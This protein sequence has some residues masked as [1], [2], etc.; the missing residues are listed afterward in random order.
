[1]ARGRPSGDKTRCSGQWTEAKFRSFIKGNLR[2]ATRKWAPI[3]QC[4]KN[5]HR[6]RG[7]YECACCHQHVPPTIYDEDK[8]KRVKNICVDHI[9]PTVDPETGFLSWD[10]VIEGLFCELDN[11]QL[12]CKA[13]HD[14]KTMEET[15]VAKLRR[16][17]E[18][19]NEE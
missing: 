10:Q 4:R 8:K 1:M 14:G 11:L 7:I 3:Q 5:A 16:S 9:N 6:G 18:N 15:M 13:C 2:S 17:K 12:L 19:S